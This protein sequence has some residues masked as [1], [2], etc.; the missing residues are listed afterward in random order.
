MHQ[1]CQRGKTANFQVLQ[2]VADT[3]L[4]TALGEYETHGFVCMLILAMCGA[5][6]LL[7]RLVIT[8]LLFRPEK[9][10]CQCALCE[11]GACA[12]GHTPHS[13]SPGCG[14]TWFII[15]MSTYII[16]KCFFYSQLTFNTPTCVHS[17]PCR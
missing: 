11:K 1:G 4:V 16:K 9:V 7:D 15:R 13:A 14:Q 3:L 17:Y 6:I 10:P 12:P 5:C 2:S 8:R